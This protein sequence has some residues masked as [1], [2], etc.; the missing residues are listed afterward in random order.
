MSVIAERKPSTLVPLDFL[1]LEGG[2]PGDVVASD[3]TSFADTARLVATLGM[4]LRF[5]LDT[6]RQAS[7]AVRV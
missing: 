4:S 5:A 1:V 2:K 6:P 7:G 3:A